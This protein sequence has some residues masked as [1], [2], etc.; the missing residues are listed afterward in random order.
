MTLNRVYYYYHYYFQ[1]TRQ[2]QLVPASVPVSATE[3]AVVA[4]VLRRF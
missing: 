1:V 3:N 4:S 2:Q